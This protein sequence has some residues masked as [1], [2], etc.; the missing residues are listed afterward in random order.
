MK[1][2]NSGNY[3]LLYLLDKNNDNFKISS[4]ILSN[5]NLGNKLLLL[6]DKSE[7]TILYLIKIFNNFIT[8]SPK[9]YIEYDELK[10]INK[11]LTRNKKIIKRFYKRR[12]FNLSFHLLNAIIYRDKKNNNR[13]LQLRNIILPLKI[14][15]LDDSYK[16]SFS[17]D[18]STND[19]FYI[20]GKYLCFLEDL[21]AYAKI[22][23]LTKKQNFNYLLPPSGD[24]IDISESN[25]IPNAKDLSDYG[26]RS[27]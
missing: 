9:G 13:N 16:I 20:S 18:N 25:I 1:Y 23:K 27:E 19:T 15:K 10:I 2:S 24:P 21:V 26:I 5:I 12:I 17:Y 7:H 6:S 8:S 3:S 4:T 22:Q 11:T 14:L